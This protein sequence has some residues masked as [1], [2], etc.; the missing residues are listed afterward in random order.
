MA[1]A[2]IED[3]DGYERVLQVSVGAH[4]MVSGNDIHIQRERCVSEDA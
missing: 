1:S 3:E 2:M 4:D